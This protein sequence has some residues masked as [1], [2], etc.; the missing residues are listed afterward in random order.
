MASDMA[1]SIK[2]PVPPPEIAGE[3]VQWFEEQLQELDNLSY[4]VALLFEG[5]SLLYSGQDAV[6]E[7]YRKQYRN[8]I[9]AA[10]EV[11]RSAGELLDRARGDASV[12]PMLKEFNFS[13]FH[14]HS[15]YKSLSIYAL[16]LPQ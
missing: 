6:M 4:G 1:T 8:V 3:T 16:R 13:A 9:R 5:I 11:S 12:I 2:F 10:S 7:T 15:V 14:D